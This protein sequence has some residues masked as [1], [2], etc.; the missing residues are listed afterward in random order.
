MKN[1]FFALA[2]TLSLLFSIATVAQ[3][4]DTRPASRALC[5]SVAAADVAQAIGGT[6]GAG[7]VTT[8]D[9]LTGIGCV[10]VDSG[11]YY[12]GL[13]LDFRTNADLLASGGQWASVTEYFEEFTRTGQPVAGLGDAAA[14]VDD[15]FPALYARRGDVSVRMTS[16]N[17][18]FANPAEHAKFE[19]LMGKILARLP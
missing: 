11:N 17:K 12:N 10:F 18:S 8:D 4:E 3:A 14:W 13:S 15:M 19:A 7:E 5:A 1:R 2:G 16:D 6:P 9:P